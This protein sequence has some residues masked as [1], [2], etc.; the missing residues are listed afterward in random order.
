M[1]DLQGFLCGRIFVQIERR[2]AVGAAARAFAGGLAGS[3]G[4][5]APLGDEVGGIGV[6]VS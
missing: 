2:F 5:L 6:S 4:V 1:R 3:G